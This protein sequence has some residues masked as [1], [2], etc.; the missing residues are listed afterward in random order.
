VLNETRTTL[1]QVDIVHIPATLPHQILVPQGVT[2]INF[3]I[4]V[5]EKQAVCS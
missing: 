5:K 4:K 2:F 1:N 3:I